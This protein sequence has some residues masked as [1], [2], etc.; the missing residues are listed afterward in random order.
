MY[1]HTHIQYICIWGFLGSSSGKE[2]TCNVGDPNLIAG[3]GRTPGGGHGNP[4]QYSCLENPQGQRSLVSYSPWGHE[5]SG[6]TERLSTHTRIHIYTH[7]YIFFL[8]FFSIT[9]YYKIL[10]YVPLLYSSSLLVIY[11]IYNSSVQFSCSVVFNSLRPHE[12]QHGRP[13]CPS[14]TPGVY[15]NPC[16]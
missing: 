1:I 12:P 16:P 7:I 2:S 8:R 9:G 13:P 14:P 15:P 6:T 4:L 11:F 5:E 10:S 3:S